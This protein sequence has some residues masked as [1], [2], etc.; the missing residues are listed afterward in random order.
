MADGCYWYPWCST[1]VSWMLSNLKRQEDSGGVG[2]KKWYP[3]SPMVWRFDVG[4][5]TDLYFSHCS[6]DVWSVLESPPPFVEHLVLVV[7]SR[8][9]RW[10]REPT[11]A[12]LAR[13]RQQPVGA[14]RVCEVTAGHWVHV[15]A[16][17]EVTA[18]LVALLTEP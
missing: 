3:D 13:L 4:A 1:F 16:P 11:K 6:T 10:R 2:C 18:L 8:S 17:D 9:E 14:V 5:A 7:A 15:D 12:Q